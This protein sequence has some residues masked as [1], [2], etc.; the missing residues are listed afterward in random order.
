MSGARMAV[1]SSALR[2]AIPGGSEAAAGAARGGRDFGNTSQLTQ[3]MKIAKQA[4]LAN[5]TAKCCATARDCMPT[6]GMAVTQT[7]MNSGPSLEAPFASACSARNTMSV[8]KP[9]SRWGAPRKAKQRNSP[10]NAETAMTR[11]KPSATL[12][13]GRM[14]ILASTTQVRTGDRKGGVHSISS[15]T[16]NASVTPNAK[17]STVWLWAVS[18][19]SVEITQ[20]GDDAQPGAADRVHQ[21]GILIGEDQHVG[22]RAITQRQIAERVAGFL[23]ERDAH[24]E[25]LW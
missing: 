9:N 7:R 22:L 14:G 10:R 2:K 5:A 21:P 17:R 8:L 15:A 24:R 6:T 25:P 23:L 20:P 19:A 13:G 12:M 3:A 16:T 1:P 11:Q 4:P 18:M